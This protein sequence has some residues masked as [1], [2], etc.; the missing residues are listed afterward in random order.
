MNLQ[1]GT[2]NNLN[3]REEKEVKV[4]R[5][6]ED[7]SILFER[8]DHAPAMTMEICEQINKVLGAEI[9]KNLFLCNRQKTEFYLLLTPSN[10]KFKTKYL[11]EQ[12]K[13]SRLSFA[14]EEF[15]IKYLN[16][17]IGSVS[18]LGLLYDSEKMVKLL[19]DREVLNG[20]YIGCHPLVNTTSLKIKTSDLLNKILPTLGYSF[21]V[22]T[23]PRED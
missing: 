18:V 16:T 22:V 3:R 5:F 15:M 1:T 21:T 19:I 17:T 6:L 14:D 9:C 7:L 8:V 10:K 13:S 23:L 12:I 4:Y 2:P 20:A 11:S